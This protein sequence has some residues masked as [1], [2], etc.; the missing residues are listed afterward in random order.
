MCFSPIDWT[1]RG[2]NKAFE[3]ARLRATGAFEAV[4]PLPGLADLRVAFGAA[5]AGCFDRAVP[6]RAKMLVG[7]SNPHPGLR[8]SDG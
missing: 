6:T 4:A 1:A 5:Y 8:H 7:M 2:P 3:R